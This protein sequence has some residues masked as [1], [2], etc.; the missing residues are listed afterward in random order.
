MMKM[1]QRFLQKIGKDKMSFKERDF[2]KKN[3]V[4]NKR[5]KKGG[6]V[7]MIAKTLKS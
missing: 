2:L 1:N 6:F 5:R 4:K 3:Y 7:S